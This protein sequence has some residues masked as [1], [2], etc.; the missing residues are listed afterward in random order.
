MTDCMG[1][2]K[3]NIVRNEWQKKTRSYF[4]ADK[5]Q[6]IGGSNRRFTRKKGQKRRGCLG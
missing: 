2:K 6:T 4:L 3:T 1:K 5:A